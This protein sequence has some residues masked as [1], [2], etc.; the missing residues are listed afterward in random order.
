MEE[1]EF[2]YL[3]KGII[4]GDHLESYSLKM[5]DHCLIS[6]EPPLGLLHPDPTGHLLCVGLETQGRGLGFWA[7]DEDEGNPA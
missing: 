6:S 2:T 1:S 4:P 3:G 7:G 5:Q